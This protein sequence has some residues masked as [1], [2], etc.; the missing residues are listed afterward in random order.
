MGL[1]IEKSIE[2]LTLKTLSKSCPSGI[3][4]IVTYAW[5]VPSLLSLVMPEGHVFRV[6]VLIHEGIHGGTKQS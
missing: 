3:L 4:G 2:L 1:M 5:Q 6:S